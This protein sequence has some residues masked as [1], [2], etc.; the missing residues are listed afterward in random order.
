MVISDESRSIIW[1]VL[2]MDTRLVDA[3]D[4]S[5]INLSSFVFSVGA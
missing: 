4:G 2:T 1:N 5:L 3:L